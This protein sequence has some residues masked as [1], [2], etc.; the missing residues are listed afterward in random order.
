M[1]R[2]VYNQAVLEGRLVPDGPVLIVEGGASLD[3]VAPDLAFVRTMRGGEP[4]VYLPG[5]SLKGVLRAHA[6]RLLWTEIGAGAA[7]SP[8]E[9]GKRREKAKELKGKD[10]PD[11]AAIYEVSCEADCLFGS[12]VLAGR[13][14]VGDAYPPDAAASDAAN[15]TEIRY[16]VAIDRA[17][18]SV[19]H[20]PF[21]QEAVVGG[22]FAFKAVLENYELWM[23]ALVLQVFDDLDAGL[24]QVGHGKSRGFGSMRVSDASLELRWPGAAPQRLEGA[25]AREPDER[26]RRVYG[27]ADDDAVDLPAGHADATQGMFGGYAYQEWDGVRAVRDACA[28]GPWR[29]FVARA[30][31]KTDGE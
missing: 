10:K 6:E 11:T 2:K 18:Q 12:T 1:F 17:K 7:E 25:G 16:G 21:E 24:V 22:A 19:K 15:R 29:A 26:T 14:R 8:F 3:P 31:E 30:K 4:T 13:F 28:A 9:D 27:L 20:G 5:S 23:L